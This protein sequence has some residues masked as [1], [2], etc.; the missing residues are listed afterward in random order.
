MSELVDEVFCAQDANKN[1]ERCSCYNVI[2]RDCHT[3]R[4][5]PGCKESLDYVEE[6]LSNLQVRTGTQQTVG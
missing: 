1:D 3:A 5:I 4:D 2:M 6:T